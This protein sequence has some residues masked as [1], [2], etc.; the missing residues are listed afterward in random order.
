M[1]PI[2]LCLLFV[3]AFT[4]SPQETEPT[5]LTSAPDG[6]RFE[7]LDFPLDFAP[8]LKL[9][10]FEELWF[11]PGMFDAES[12]SYF[13]YVLAMQIDNR[14][15]LD[16]ASVK[17]LFQGYFFGLCRAVSESRQLQLELDKIATEVTRTEAGWQVDVAMFDAFGDGRELQ[18]R[19]LVSRHKSPSGTGLVL[20]GL[21]SPASADAAIWEELAQFRKGWE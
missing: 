2:L 9:E 4:A 13:S 20:L 18:L 19:L 7:R 6:W 21:A 3:T 16:E 12:E 14:S 11:A 10:G 17:D 8:D 15:E 1:Q 5:L